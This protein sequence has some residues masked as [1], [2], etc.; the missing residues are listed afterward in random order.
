MIKNAKINVV[1]N[2]K[3]KEMEQIIDSEKEDSHLYLW[4]L[5]SSILD[6]PGVLYFELNY[7]KKQ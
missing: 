2:Q 1:Y 6:L 7:F 3:T 4:F 5:R